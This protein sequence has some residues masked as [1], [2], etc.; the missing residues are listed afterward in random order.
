M[1]NSTEMENEKEK[2][3]VKEVERN[4]YRAT[5]RQTDGKGWTK[6]PSNVDRR[7]LS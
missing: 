3:R 1:G 4:R 7:E 6:A 5:G 2:Y